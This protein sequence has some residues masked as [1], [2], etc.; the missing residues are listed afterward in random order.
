LEAY[1]LYDMRKKLS[2]KVPQNQHISLF[3][4]LR[5][6]KISNTQLKGSS[7]VVIDQEQKIL[8]NTIDKENKAFVIVGNLKGVCSFINPIQRELNRQRIEEINVE[9]MTMLFNG[10]A[11]NQKQIENNREENKKNSVDLWSDS[12]SSKSESESH[13]SPMKINNESDS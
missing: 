8:K 2:P 11:I 9:E 13:P 5:H 6:L 1:R 4:Y 12:D 7:L 10:L 3:Y